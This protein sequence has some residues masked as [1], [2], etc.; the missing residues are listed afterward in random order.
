MLYN[1]VLASAIFLLCSV[2]KSC[3]TLC[4]FMDYSTPGFPITISQSLFKLKSIV[5]VMLS[6]HLILCGPLLLLPLIFPSIRVFSSKSVLCI[7]WPNYWSFSFSISPSN[8]YS[9]L[10]S[11]RMDW[12]D[13]LAVQGPLKSL[14]WHHSSEVSVLW[15]SAFFM[16]PLSH[17]HMTTEKASTIQTFIGGLMALLFN[18]LSRFL[19]A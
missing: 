10:I 11:S 8:E 13:L 4:H 7:R 15:R 2:A 3:L 6:N 17:L 5:S 1:I 18:M 16:V 19:I 12:F 9:G 14:F